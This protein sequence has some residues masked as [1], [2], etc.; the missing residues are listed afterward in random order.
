MENQTTDKVLPL[1]LI[2]DDKKE[3][4]QQ[5]VFNLKKKGLA[6]ITAT[7]LSEAFWRIRSSPSIDL[8][9]CDINFDPEDPSNAEGVNIANKIKQENP[10]LPMVAYSGKL[11]KSDLENVLG[12]KH[13]FAFR[14]SKG[15]RDRYNQEVTDWIKAAEVHQKSRQQE[16]KDVISNNN[17]T[18]DINT[19]LNKE[20]IFKAEPQIDQENDDNI[21][22]TFEENLK[23]AGVKLVIF[24][25][26]EDNPSPLTEPENDE[27]AMVYTF[28]RIKKPF[29]V[30]LRSYGHN[31]ELFEAEV[32][33]ID[34]LRTTGNKQEICFAQLH[35]FLLECYDNF[36]ALNVSWTIEQKARASNFLN[37]HI[38]KGF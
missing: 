26:C 29:I 36:E 14:Y 8:L 16:S 37:H 25:S 38:K 18:I 33:Q 22:L 35:K 4:L 23:K 9:I 15:A 6:C 7:S 17:S 1:A 13:P 2:V 20:S 32:Y 28:S 24:H 19:I 10:A 21:E 3:H 31:S 30:W 5:R 27:G 34:V 12:K 11:E